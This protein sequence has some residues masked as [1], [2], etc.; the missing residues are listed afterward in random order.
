[1]IVVWEPHLEKEWPDLSIFP[2]KQGPVQAP[3]RELARSQLVR[4]QGLS[5]LAT[6]Q[7]S[8]ARQDP[9]PAVFMVSPG[10]WIQQVKGVLFVTHCSCL[11]WCVTYFFCTKDSAALVN[12]N[13]LLACVIAFILWYFCLLFSFALLYSK[14]SSLMFPLSST[15]WDCW[16]N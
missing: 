11:L 1:M 12:K 10:R 6:D 7:V 14:M 15:S 2:C 3:G 8:L 13:S 16:E 4:P 5:H 9:L